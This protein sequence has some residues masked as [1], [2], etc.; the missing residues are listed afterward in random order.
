MEKADVL[1]LLKA[2]LNFLTLSEERERHLSHLI[3]A[4]KGMM[5][6]EGA[7][8]SEPYSAEEVQ[9]L[10]MYA[11]HLFRKRATGEP[12]PRMLRWA[13]NNQIFAQKAGGTDVT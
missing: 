13:L 7:S 12:M 2:D 5:V 6:R 11:A 9:L 8:L 4:A 3:D 1:E 10:V